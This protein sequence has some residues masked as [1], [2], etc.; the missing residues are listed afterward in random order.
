MHS[1]FERRATI[2]WH[3]T[4]ENCRVNMSIGLHVHG[5]VRTG[6]NFDKANPFY[7]SLLHTH[8][9][10]ALHRGYNCFLWRVI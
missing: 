5:G 8:T 2:S 4:T 1:A 7:P 3:K 9:D 10:T 6:R